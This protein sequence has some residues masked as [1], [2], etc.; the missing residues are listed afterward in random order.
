MRREEGKENPPNACEE[1][2]L[3]ALCLKVIKRVMNRDY[4]DPRLGVLRGE[5]SVEGASFSLHGQMPAKPHRTVSSL[6]CL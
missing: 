4:A 5:G 2:K 1:M 3:H 6:C